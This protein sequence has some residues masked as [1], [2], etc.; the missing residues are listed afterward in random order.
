MNSI[1]KNWGGPAALVGAA[2][3]GVAL[4]QQPAESAEVA[5]VIEPPAVDEPAGS[6]HAAT[7]IFAGGCFWGVQGVFQHVKG[8]KTAVSG[9]AGGEGRNANYEAVSGGDTGHAESVKITYD[10]AQISYGKLLQ[11]FFS[12][13]HNPTELNRQGPDSGTQYRSAIFPQTP[14]QRSVAEKYIA[15]LDASHAFKKPLATKIEMNKFFYPAE[16]YHQNYLTL[17]PSDPYI[18]FNDLPKI[19]NLKRI[20]PDVYRADPVLVRKGL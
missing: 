5:V 1:L 16:T 13:A 20:A 11:I 18:A 3:F 6:E 4:W 10:P 14:V 17:H 2:I 15:Q 19:E 9:Y 12:V 7:A 8:V